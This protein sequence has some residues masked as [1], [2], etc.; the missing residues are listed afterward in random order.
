MEE[1]IGSHYPWGHL[2]CICNSKAI[3]S[4]NA[5]KLLS[6]PSLGFSGV[7]IWSK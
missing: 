6:G 5:V 3:Q 7:T 4:V 1:K 2:D